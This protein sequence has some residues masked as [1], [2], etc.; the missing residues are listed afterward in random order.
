MRSGGAPARSAYTAFFPKVYSRFERD[1]RLTG[2]L[3][4]SAHGPPAFRI[5][6]K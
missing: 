3:F 2:G 4:A 1:G 6:P 5:F